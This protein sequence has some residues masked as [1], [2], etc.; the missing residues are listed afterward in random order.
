MKNRKI[1]MLGLSVALAMILSY[2]EA[3]FPL[4]FAVPGIKMGLA[5]IVIIFI[6][7]KIGFKEAVMISLVR[8]FLSS[9]LFGNIMAL[10]YSLSGAVLS[11]LIMFVLKKTDK[12]S[13]VGVSIVGAVMHNA[14]Q[15]LMAILIMETQQII[16]YMPAL[17]VSG[18]VTGVLI[19]IVASIVIK[20]IKNI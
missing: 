11:L 9:L 16:F 4:N 12:F 13:V 20:R 18:T 6:L 10:A 3:L 1:A 14:G 17:A 2:I 7:Y 19:G 5:N 15:I 8:V